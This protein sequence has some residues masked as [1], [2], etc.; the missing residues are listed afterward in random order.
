MN[1]KIKPTTLFLRRLRG[2][3]RKHHESPT[4]WERG[5]SVD[6]N[7]NSLWVGW[8]HVMIIP[9]VPVQNDVK[10]HIMMRMWV[11]EVRSWTPADQTGHHP[12]MT[13]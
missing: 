4:P 12:R 8:P 10:I 7:V 1:S 6:G 13:G 2:R 5:W 3:L 11:N 9:S